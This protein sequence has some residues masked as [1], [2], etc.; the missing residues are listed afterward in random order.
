M[1]PIGSYSRLPWA[2]LLLTVLPLITG[3]NKKA[4]ET[5]EVPVIAQAA[6]P[7][8]AP[9]S[10]EIA[11]DAVL[12]PLA[13]AAISPRISAPIRA[14]YVQRGAHVR[15][16]QLLVTL[17]NRD[18][19]GSALDSKGAVASARANYK[20]ITTAT[21][22]E[23]VKKAQLDADQLKVALDVA[24]RAAN[25]RRT[26]YQ[27]GALS[28][29][30]ADMAYAAEAQAQAAYDVARQ[31]AESM[32][33]TTQLTDKES[34]QGLLTS[35]QGR[36]ENAEAQ[37]DY[38]N[39]RSPIAGVVTDRPLFPGET[40]PAG[41]PVITI[42]DTSALLAKLHIA[43]ATAQ[44]LSLGHKAEVT[45]PG[46]EDPVEASVS[47][48][49][50]ALDPGST[51]VEVWLKLPNS[52]GHLKVGTPVHAVILGATISNAL[53]VPAA[54][55]LP[56]TDG[57]NAVMVIGADGTAKKQA[58]K[59]GIRTPETVQVTS[60]LSLTDMVVTAGG[61]GLDDGTKVTVGKAGSSEDKE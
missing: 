58:I 4:E 38:A 35:A 39:L 61:Y 19:Q 44:K 18:L 57:G 9:I 46:V 13:Q 56:A 7:T 30:D 21:I 25:E 51:T 10:E 41:T 16:G 20:A 22:P 47:F 59:V 50:P 15:A 52:D 40:A 17:E 3:C 2:C 43:Q 8:Q 31:H 53:Q 32:S 27:Q 34:A 42:M 55:I 26:L 14:E 5:P 24:T 54:A 29:R 11:V 12:A 1:K 48:I 33:K 45:V 60:G 23:N 37:V 6:H 49:S 28:G 36:F